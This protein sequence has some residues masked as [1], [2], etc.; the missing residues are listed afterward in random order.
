MLGNRP[1]LDDQDGVSAV[2]FAL[3]APVFL[4]ML[5]GVFDLGYN[6]YAKSIL[7]GAMQSAARDSSIEGAKVKTLNQS[8]RTS[9]QK[10]MPRA[11]LTF[12]RKAY[13]NFTDVHQ[14]ED[15]DDI[16]GNG[17]CDNGEPFEDANGNGV[18][19]TDRG[20]SGKGDAREAVLYTVSMEY[21]R[22]FPVARFVGMSNTFTTSESTVLRN[23]PFTLQPNR[24]VTE[25]CV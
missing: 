16:D 25:N 13:A 4:M 2:E 23:Q 8:I 15:F 22:A 21:E 9:V 18:W 5:M 12:E 20:L 7:Q 24:T 3:I 1:I 6:I 17:K 19:D 11:K 10:A 14:A